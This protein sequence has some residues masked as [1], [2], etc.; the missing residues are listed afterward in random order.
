MLNNLMNEY[1]KRIADAMSSLE[2]Y[3]ESM[4]FKEAPNEELLKLSEES[5]KSIGYAV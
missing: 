5:L 1:L 3:V 4:N 2:Y